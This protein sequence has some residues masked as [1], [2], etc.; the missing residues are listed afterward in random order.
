MYA[1]VHAKCVC[2]IE[3]EFCQHCQLL[4][5]FKPTAQWVNVDR[6]AGQIA[7]VHAR[8]ARTRTYMHI[9]TATL[10]KS[11]NLHASVLTHGQLECVKWVQ[12]SWAKYKRLRSPYNNYLLSIFQFERCINCLFC[13]QHKQT[14]FIGSLYLLISFYFLRLFLFFVDC[15]LKFILLSLMNA[16]TERKSD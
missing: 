3:F 13:V 2:W 14:Q 11:L 10:C 16:L 4:S 5:L 6:V 7:S 1:N 15:R 8:K 12:S 9:P